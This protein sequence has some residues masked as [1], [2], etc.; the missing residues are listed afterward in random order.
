[1]YDEYQ[2]RI[3]NNTVIFKGVVLGVVIL[4]LLSLILAFFSNIITALSLS[5]L[6]TVLIIGN[7]MIIGFIGFF[8]A[9][10]VEENGWLNGGLGGLI[11]MAIIILLGTISMPI[12][13]G[14]I[15]LLLILGLLVGAIGGIIGIN[16]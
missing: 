1:M 16:L 4:I 12:S 2:E 9:R 13:I 11:Y 10:R 8:I 15:F 7:F 6:N 3:I 5:S 14:N